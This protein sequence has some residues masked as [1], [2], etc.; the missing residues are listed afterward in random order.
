MRSRSRR[1]STWGVSRTCDESGC[2]VQDA[3]GPLFPP[4]TPY[5]LKSLTL[6]MRPGEHLE[7]L[8]R[9]LPP[10]LQASGATLEEIEICGSGELPAECGAALAQV[11]HACSSTIK[12]VRLLSG[13][14]C[15]LGTPFVQASVPGLTSCCDT[16]EVLRCPWTFFSALPAT[17]PSFSRLTELSLWGAPVKNVDFTQKA[18]DIMA[19]GRLPALATLSVTL[20]L[21]IAFASL[22]RDR[23]MEGRCRLARALEAVAG[24][25]RRLT[26]TGALGKHL[27]AGACYELGAAVGKL[28]R[29]R[30][31]KLDILSDGRDYHAVGRGVAFSGGCPELF[32]L[33]LNGLEKNADWLTFKPTLIV[34]SVRNFQ[35]TGLTTDEEALLLCCGWA[36]AVGPRA[37]P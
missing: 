4:F 1:W 21:E 33:R 17:G 30:Y 34:P 32:Q 13:W 19:N 3:W 12:T 5:S 6:G 11:L 14:G 20:S 16:L 23:I 26:L 15:V 25:L 37:P 22:K 36:G 35:V 28:R 24:T 9:E 31:L 18:W 29:L 2:W 7:G 10:M 27:P 8:L